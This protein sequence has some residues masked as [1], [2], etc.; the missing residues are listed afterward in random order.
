MNL[1]RIHNLAS[2]YGVRPS[3]FFE[4]ETDIGAFQLDEACLI[5]GRQIEHNLHEGKPAFEG[6][7]GG[8]VKREYRSVKHLATKKVKLDADG[9]W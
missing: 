1:A 7:G 4:F 2:A 6:I 8:N 3:D 5:V 9:L